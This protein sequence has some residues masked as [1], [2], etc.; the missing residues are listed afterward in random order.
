M[1]AHPGAASASSPTTSSSA[2]TFA[3]VRIYWPSKKFTDADLIPGGG[4]AT[5]QAEQENFAAVER[6]LEAL[7]EDQ[8][9]LVPLST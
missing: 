5:A 4:A 7:E 9:R 6:V 8:D 1:V 3:A 2:R